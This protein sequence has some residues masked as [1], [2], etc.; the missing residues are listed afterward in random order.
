MHKYVLQ[1]DINNFQAL[2][3]ILYLIKSLPVSTTNGSFK[4]MFS[5]I[6]VKQVSCAFQ[7]NCDI[8]EIGIKQL[9]N[10]VIAELTDIKISHIFTTIFLLLMIHYDLICT[11]T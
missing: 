2:F 6:L 5:S 10:A 7:E 4:K 11:M 9:L 3:L 8:I 1:N